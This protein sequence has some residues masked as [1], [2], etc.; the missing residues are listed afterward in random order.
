MFLSLYLL[1]KLILRII[2]FSVSPLRTVDGIDD[3]LF[4]FLQPVQENIEV[5]AVPVIINQPKPR[6][7]III[8]NPANN[9]IINKSIINS[10]CRNSSLELYCADALTF[11]QSEIASAHAQFS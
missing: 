10:K 4:D 7:K 9:K 6:T 8:Q 5:E 11:Y 1:T 2:F 3:S